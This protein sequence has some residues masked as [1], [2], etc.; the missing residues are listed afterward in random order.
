MS[1]DKIA[2]PVIKQCWRYAKDAHELRLDDLYAKY[3]IIAGKTTF[4]GKDLDDYYI[5]QD[6]GSLI[7]AI[8]GSRDKNQWIANMVDWLRSYARSKANAAGIH[9]TIDVSAD[10]VVDAVI[11]EISKTHATSVIITGVSRGAA[12]AGLAALRLSRAIDLPNLCV[13]FASPRFATK[14]FWRREKFPDTLSMVHVVNGPDIVPHIPSRAAGW[15]HPPEEQRIN[16][17]LA[18]TS[19]D[20]WR[21]FKLWASWRLGRGKKVNLPWFDAHKIESNDEAISEL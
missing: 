4:Q 3:K 7:I 11:E 1:A 16:I 8:P 19:R 5:I 14:V 12:I 21:A 6:A 17:G 9:G 10:R 18:L 15:E 2:I 20:K 13:R